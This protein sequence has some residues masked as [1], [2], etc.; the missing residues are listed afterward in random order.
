M[1]IIYVQ[2]NNDTLGFHFDTG[3]RKTFL[4]RTYLDKYPSTNGKQ[5]SKTIGGAGGTKQIAI[6]Q[7]AELEGSVAG[8]SATLKEVSIKQEASNSRE[9]NTY[10]NLGQDFLKQFKYV[11]INFDSMFIELGDD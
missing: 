11:R 2:S 10:G 1:P 6:V 3:A 5:T 9:S 8:K 4:F 7:L